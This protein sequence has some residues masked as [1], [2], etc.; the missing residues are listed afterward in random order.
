MIIPDSEDEEDEHD[1][2]RPSAAGTGSAMLDRMLAS[3]GDEQR[4]QHSLPL[5]HPHH[6][7]QEA[8]PAGSMPGPEEGTRSYTANSGAGKTHSSMS[9]SEQPSC[10]NDDDAAA[11][12]GGREVWPSGQQAGQSNDSS[13]DYALSSDEGQAD[14]DADAAYRRKH[15]LAPRRLNMSLATAQLP[16]LPAASHLRA[17]DGAL[18][19]AGSRLRRQS[20]AAP[21]PQSRYRHEPAAALQEGDEDADEDADDAG[22]D[23]E[24]SMAGAGD[25]AADRP[26]QSNGSS[27]Q[28][29]A[30]VQQSFITMRRRHQ[31]ERLS[32]ASILQPSVSIKSEPMSAG[33]GSSCVQGSEQRHRVGHMHIALL[34]SA[35]CFA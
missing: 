26:A 28:I 13:R 6:Q 30:S 27:L 31:H 21:G 34:T 16:P 4:Q 20:G 29:Q 9:I 19:A 3:A 24:Y 7:R 1:D 17:S 10:S 22:A 35:S 18:P 11:Y 8:S 12:G 32:D 2:A 15:S 23:A 5:Q 33:G 25:D 14:A